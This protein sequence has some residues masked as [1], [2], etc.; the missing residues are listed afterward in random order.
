[1]SK[2]RASLYRS[3]SRLE[4]STS[5]ARRAVAGCSGHRQRASFQVSPAQARESRGEISLGHQSLTPASHQP[6]W[7]SQNSKGGL[8][9]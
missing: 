5:G 9:L 3:H 4:I 1:M 7:I 8:W 2:N 6:K